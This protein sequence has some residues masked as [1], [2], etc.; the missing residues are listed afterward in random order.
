MEGAQGTEV[1]P[2]KT[3]PPEVLTSAT[4]V[5]ESGAFI[6]ISNFK[7]FYICFANTS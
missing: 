5:V 4:E 1:Q 6:Y 7:Y 2:S 3:L